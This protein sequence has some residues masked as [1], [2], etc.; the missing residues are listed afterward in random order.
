MDKQALTLPN[1]AFSIPASSPQPPSSAC[2]P[3][4]RR[5]HSRDLLGQDRE[6]EIEHAGQLYRLRLTQLGKLILTK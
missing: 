4:P 2:G 6:L 5:L 1:P 3:A